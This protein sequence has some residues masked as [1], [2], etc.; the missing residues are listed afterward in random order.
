MDSL[1]RGLEYG[2][3]SSRSS[4]AFSAWSLNGPY[5]GL[6]RVIAR[7]RWADQRNKHLGSVFGTIRVFA[8]A[9]PWICFF[10]TTVQLGK[11]GS[12]PDLG[13][14]GND[15]DPRSFSDLSMGDHTG[16]LARLWFFRHSD[17]QGFSG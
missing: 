16:L 6:I 1:K 8:S 9:Y 13:L 4:A 11:P 7:H 10:L 2:L 17:T 15:T 12:L 5:G 14:S 3:E